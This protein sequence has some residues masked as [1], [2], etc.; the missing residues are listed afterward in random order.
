VLESVGNF[1]AN[2]LIS[3]SV[4]CRERREA[5][6]KC[7]IPCRV[8]KVKAFAQEQ[9]DTSRKR[10]HFTHIFD[11]EGTASCSALPELFRFGESKLSEHSA[12]RVANARAS[13]PSRVDVCNTT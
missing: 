11:E 8:P 12:A 13:F 5:G 1:P 2:L 9:L 10:H 7:Q 3:V 4:L 6:G